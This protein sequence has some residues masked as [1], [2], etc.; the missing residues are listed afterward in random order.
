MPSLAH[1]LVS[2]RT[3]ECLISLLDGLIDPLV[4]LGIQW[5]D[6]KVKLSGPECLLE[7]IM[8]KRRLV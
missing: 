5:A 1:R 3:Q 4:Q 7:D 6:F 8:G 2:G